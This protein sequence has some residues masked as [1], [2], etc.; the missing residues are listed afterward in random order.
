[1]LEVCERFPRIGTIANYQALPPGERALYNHHTLLKIEQEARS[2][3]IRI[4][5][6]RKGG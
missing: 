6:T 3:A 2:P 4:D 1:M 5:T